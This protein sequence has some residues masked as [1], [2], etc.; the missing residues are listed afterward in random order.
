MCCWQLLHEMQ[1]EGTMANLVSSSLICLHCMHSSL[2]KHVLSTRG[3]EI[4]EHMTR[5]RTC[6]S[7]VMCKSKLQYYTILSIHAFLPL[8]TQIN[9]LCIYFCRMVARHR[10]K[11]DLGQHRCQRLSLGVYV[12]QAGWAC[13]MMEPWERCFSKVFIYTGYIQK[14][15]CKI[16]PWIKLE[17]CQVSTTLILWSWVINLISFWTKWVPTYILPE[18]AVCNLPKLGGPAKHVPTIHGEET[19]T[20]PAGPM[21]SS[22]NSWYPPWN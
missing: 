21:T 7:Q 17:A 18:I 10:T 15:L 11:H 4:N 5:W 12:L 13:S 22:I 8:K 3:L 20:E 2:W 19:K 9:S 6:S 1:H 16:I 14:N